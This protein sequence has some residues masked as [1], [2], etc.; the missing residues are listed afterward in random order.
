MIYEEITIAINKVFCPPLFAHF[1]A[2]KQTLFGSHF[3]HLSTAIDFGF[4]KL[5]FGTHTAAVLRTYFWQHFH[6]M[7]GVDPGVGEGELGELSTEG[8]HPEGGLGPGTLPLCPLQ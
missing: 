3:A 5:F 4:K 1:V 8:G 7:T 2:L 6:I